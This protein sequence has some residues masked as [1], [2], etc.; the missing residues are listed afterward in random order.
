[1]E[2]NSVKLGFTPTQR[3]AIY[4]QA[5]DLFKT[6]GVLFKY[7]CA[8]LCKI[9]FNDPAY[10]AYGDTYEMFVKEYFPEYFA[11]LTDMGKATIGKWG[12]ALISKLPDNAARCEALAEAIKRV[13]LLINQ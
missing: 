4:Q 13:D 7:S 11:V 5:Y 2:A 6:P 1:M 8:E 9:A 3:R 12:R 10:S